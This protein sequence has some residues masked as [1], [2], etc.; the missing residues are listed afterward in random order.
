MTTS[1]T[2]G[3]SHI[4]GGSK[5]SPF[6]YNETSHFIAFPYYFNDTLDTE[7]YQVKGPLRFAEWKNGSSPYKINQDVKYASDQSAKMRKE[8]VKNAIKHG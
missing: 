3:E 7:N 1:T 8:H 4:R 5:E 6:V 2:F